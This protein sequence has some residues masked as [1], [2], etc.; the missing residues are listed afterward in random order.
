MPIMSVWNGSHWRGTVVLSDMRGRIC[1]VCKQL[2]CLQTRHIHGFCIYPNNM[3]S[4]RDRDLCK[5]P[6]RHHMRAV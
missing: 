5:Q 3:C 1:S 2:C 4:L 6:D